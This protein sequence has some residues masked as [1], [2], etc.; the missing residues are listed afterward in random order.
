MPT[1]T[2][3][4]RGALRKSALRQANER[5]ILDAVRQNPGISR[6]DLTCITG[7]SASSIS[8][9]VSRLKRANVLA[10]QTVEKHSQVGRKPTALR[11]VES[12]RTAVAVE[13]SPAGSR[14]ALVDMAGGIVREEVA[15]WHANHEIVIQ[16]IHVAVRT[17]VEKA[18][19][20]T[21]VLGVGVGL[22]GTV[23]RM[24]G[25]VIAAENLNW[26]NVEVGPAL[27]GRM[28]LPFYY[29]NNAKLSAIAERWFTE[30]GRKAPQHFVFVTPVC[31]LGTGI[32]AEGQLLQGS[33]GMAGEF[34]HTTIYPDGLECP[35]GNRGCLEQ[36][37]SDKALCAFYAQEA[38]LGDAPPDP[39]AIVRM[40]RAG[41]P[42]AVRAL[43]KTAGAL[44]LG[45]VNLV[46][47]FNPEAIVV[48]G[49]VAEAWDL[50]SETIW[51]V[52]RRRLPHYV[53][54]ELRAYPSKHAADSSLLGAASLVFMRYFT[55]FE[56]GE[57][58]GPSRRVLMHAAG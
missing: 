25:R 22:P 58:G 19:A 51:R 8:F 3:T 39:S 45:L 49:Y 33:A 18:R 2:F 29:E 17:M 41:E 24:D 50:I 10:E 44:A 52:L 37:A 47:V 20:T 56:H 54:A 32:I 28:Q 55:S 42:A 14:I 48:G 5:L 4:T 21:E 35:C 26:F 16:R 57:D 46:W 43:E 40:A 1:V 9:I 13:V 15:Q 38:G 27:R 53:L 23:G 11:L 34:G 30:P 31:G 36:Y 6:S 12:A 7:L